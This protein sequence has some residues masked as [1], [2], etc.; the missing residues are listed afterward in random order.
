MFAVANN[1]T[2]AEHGSQTN[3]DVLEGLSKHS[4]YKV[5]YSG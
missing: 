4:L 5:G 1:R 3:T 2:H